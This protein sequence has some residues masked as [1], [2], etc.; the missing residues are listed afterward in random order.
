VSTRTLV[1]KTGTSLTAIQRPSSSVAAGHFNPADIATINA[2]VLYDN[3]PVL[4]AY[5]S[6]TPN[7]LLTVPRRGQLIVHS[8]DVVAVDASGN[9]IIVSAYSIAQGL[10][11]TLT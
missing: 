6:L 2:A 3:N 1:T 4:H 9:V 5:G 11:W 7:G 10:S 8:G